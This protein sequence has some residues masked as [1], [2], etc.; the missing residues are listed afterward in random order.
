LDIKKGNPVRLGVTRLENGYNFAVRSGLECIELELYRIDDARQ[1][2]RKAPDILVELNREYKTGD[3]FSVELDDVDLKEY[4]YRYADGRAQVEDDYAATLYGCGRFGVED[5]SS[6]RLSRVEMERFDWGNDSAPGLE[7]SDMIV[8]KLHARGFT[9][10]RSSQVAT[11][12]RGT[13]AGIT[14]KLPYLKELGVTTLELMPAYEFDEIQRLGESAGGSTGTHPLAPVVAPRKMLNY[15]G[16]TSGHHF[17]PKAAYTASE[18]RDYCDYTT[19]LKELVKKLHENGMELVMEMYFTHEESYLID[20]CLRFWVLEYHVD[21]FHLYCDEDRLNQVFADPVLG[22][23][24]IFTMHW[25]REASYNGT[26]RMASYNSGFDEVAKKLLKGDENQLSHFVYLLKN[27]S[28]N[29]GVINY[30][31][32]HNGFTLMDLVSYDRKHNEANGEDNRDGDNFNYSWNCGCE[33][34]SHKKKINELRLAQVKNAFLMLMTAQGT[35]LILAGDEFGNS[36]G[37]N[38]NPYCQDNETTW[39][40]WKKTKMS[41]EIHD[42]LKAAIRFRREHGILHLSTPLCSSDSLSCG[43]PDVSC[44]GDM[45]WFSRME[46]FER[47]V[48]LMYCG[49]YDR[50]EPRDEVV[51]I[52]YNLHWEPHTLA[53]PDLDGGNGWELAMTTAQAERCEINDRS[54]AVPPRSV[55]ILVGGI[56]PRKDAARTAARSGAVRRSGKS[57]KGKKLVSVGI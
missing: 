29:T 30:V 10:H 35:P 2:K 45:A 40:E 24:K 43:Y 47:H 25:D 28:Y 11:E 46:S 5:D 8:Y 4:L 23:T 57:G 53:L 41:V 18:G 12:H 7:Y 19:E 52:A 32:N 37:G 50:L 54:V 56:A 31:T 36:Q 27:N 26:K 34:P 14:E 39:L 21:G 17:A 22:R 20:D 44:H 55:S 1:D 49:R 48:G 51:Y 6:L 42:F 3:V 38:N 9:K 33:G 16:Y 13:F 15:W